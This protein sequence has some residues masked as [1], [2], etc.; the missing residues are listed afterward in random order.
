MMEK[1]THQLRF[2]EALLVR[3]RTPSLKTA[4]SK[5]RFSSDVNYHTLNSLIKP[6]LAK[7]LSFFEKWL[8]LWPTFKSLAQYSLATAA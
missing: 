8:K 3:K 1:K 6:T 4:P 5:I 2:L 7:D